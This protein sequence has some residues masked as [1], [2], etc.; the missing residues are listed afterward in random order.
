MED[1][2]NNMNGNPS[3]EENYYGI[4][5]NDI[6]RMLENQLGLPPEDDEEIER[7]RRIVNSNK[8]SISKPN[9]SIDNIFEEKNGK[10][11]MKNNE[12]LNK[13]RWEDG[14]NGILLIR[15]TLHNIQSQISQNFGN[16][17]YLLERLQKLQ[18]SH[19]KL[20]GRYYHL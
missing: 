14:E 7:L 9:S 3:E 11:Y 6:F 15:E 17:K 2:D 5:Q 12:S 4:S 10:F 16:K 1:E 13:L 18:E 8:N 19:M 20:C